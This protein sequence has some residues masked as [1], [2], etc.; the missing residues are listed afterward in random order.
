M[1]RAELPTEGTP[2]G[3]AAL[4]AAARAAFDRGDYRTVRALLRALRECDHEE[5][6]ALHQDLSDRLRP[7]PGLLVLQLL[8]LLF[9]LLLAAFALTG[10]TTPPPAEAPSEAPRREGPPTLQDLLP[11][12]DRTVSSFDAEGDPPGPT[13]VILEIERPTPERAELWIAGR[14]ERL[15]LSWDSVQRLTGGLWLRTPLEE[16][17]TFPGSFGTVKI[18]ATEETVTVPA[19]TFTDCLLTEEKSPSED[20]VALTTFCP[21]VGLTEL[22]IQGQGAEG[23]ESV[24]LRLRSHGPRVE[25]TPAGPGTPSGR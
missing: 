25:L 16:G 9:L 18:L 10:C 23:A 17:A 8:A 19:G 3:P 14:P 4:L 13:L 22:L 20:K 12:T 11:L 2:G 15:L 7:A 24:H 1:D 6:Q 5:A 21:G